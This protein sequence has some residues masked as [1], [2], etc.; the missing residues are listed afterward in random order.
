VRIIRKGQ[1]GR[2]EIEFS[3]EDELRRL[4]ETMLGERKAP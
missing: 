1:G 2:V 4:Y 3:G